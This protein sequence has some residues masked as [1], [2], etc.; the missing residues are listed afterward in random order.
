MKKFIVHYNEI[1]LKGNNRG[2]FES[3]L[4]KNLKD[5]IKGKI[6]KKESRI[7]IESEENVKEILGNTFGIEWYAPITEVKPN[8]EEIWEEVKKNSGVY[9][10]K[11][12]K[13]E[14]KRSDKGFPIKS[15]DVSKEIGAR[16]VDEFKNKVKMKNP[17]VKIYIEIVKDVAYIY[18]EKN[19]GLGGLPVGTAGKVLCLLSG[20]ID[21]IVSAFLMMKRGC[22]VD[23][24]HIHSF[25]ENNKVEESKIPKMVKILEKF[26]NKGKLFLIPY[27]IF[28]EKMLPVDPKYEV[29]MFRRFIY[30]LAEKISK[31]K[32]LGIVCGDSL[33]QVASQTLENINAIQGG[34]SAP[35]FRPLISF[36]KMEI[37]ELAKKIGS[38]ELSIQ[39]Y[40]DCCSLVAEKHPTT[41]ANKEKVE[42]FSKEIN[43]DEVIEQ[44]LKLL[45]CTNE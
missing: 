10:D 5:K 19:K 26:G 30:L 13:V 15:M 40:K 3:A 28:Y 7:V 22:T 42:K 20:G 18:F 41:K 9:K 25:Y 32:Y 17:E 12:I 1:A 38:F 14:T 31:G 34:I 4:V 33:G 8:L 24:L 37:V 45:I 36:D 35:V 21:S 43:I 6:S 27:R 23:F 39:E 44:S 11:T 2:Y 29:V 16:I